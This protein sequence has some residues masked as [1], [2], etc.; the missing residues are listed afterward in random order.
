MRARNLL[1]IIMMV[2]E[3]SL[4][5]FALRLYRPK[6]IIPQTTSP[7]VKMWIV[8]GGLIQDSRECD[9]HYLNLDLAY[10][11]NVPRLE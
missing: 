7:Q 4:L 5:S 6:R 10:T 8:I 2:W 9:I 3:I 1:D 11:R